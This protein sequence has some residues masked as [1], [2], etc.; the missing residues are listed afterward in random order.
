MRK[1]TYLASSSTKGSIAPLA[2][3][4][5]PMYPLMISLRLEDDQSRQPFVNMFGGFIH[6]VGMVPIGTGFLVDSVS[7]RPGL[8][9]FDHLMRSTVHCGRYMHTVSVHRGLF[10]EVVG[11]I[12]GDLFIVFQQQSGGPR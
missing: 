1:C 12:D 11:E 6:Q 7:G 4:V 2:R 3:K 8:R 5:S 9:K 10:G